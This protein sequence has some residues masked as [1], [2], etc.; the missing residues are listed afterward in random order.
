MDQINLTPLLNPES[1]HA[2]YRLSPVTCI[3]IICIYVTVEQGWPTCGTLA[4]RST[5]DVIE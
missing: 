2:A 4:F 5:F 3:Y 1:A